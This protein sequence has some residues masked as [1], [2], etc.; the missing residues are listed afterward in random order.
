MPDKREQNNQATI[1]GEIVSPFTFSH[2]T[3]GERFYLVDAL[4][5]RLSSS[6]DRIPLMVSEQ[7]LKESIRFGI[8]EIETQKGEK[9]K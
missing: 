8:T 4:T 2:E 3:C 1:I 5:K 7:L 9:R 6:D